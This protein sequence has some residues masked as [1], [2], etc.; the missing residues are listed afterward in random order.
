MLFFKFGN[1]RGFAYD[2]LMSKK[3]LAPKKILAAA[4]A[5]ARKIITTDGGGHDWPHIERVRR[6]ARKIARAEKVDPFLPELMALLHELHDRKVVG[7][8]QEAKGLAA[9]KKWLLTQGLPE[10][11]IAEVMDVITNQSY[12]ASGIRGQKLGSRAGQ[13]MQDA[14]RLEAIGAI[15]IARCFAYNGKK[16][17]PIHD[18]SITPRT[19]KISAAEYKKDDDTSINH[20]YEKLLKLTALMNTKTGKRIARRRHIFLKNFLA[21]FLAEWSGTR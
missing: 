4:E 20:F 18:P 21:E 9:T 5:Y 15:G 7:Y 6:M 12:S 17:N 14:D 2:A 10:D 16:G 8:G 1:N 11:I 3:T 19:K 13:I